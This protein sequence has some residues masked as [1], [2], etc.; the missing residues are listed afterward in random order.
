MVN[1]GDDESDSL[2]VQGDDLAWEDMKLDWDAYTEN[3]SE[4]KK[5]GKMIKVFNK[6][7]G[8]VRKDEKRCLKR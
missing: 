4:P 8:L 3:T 7:I 1:L 5:V 6:C 2:I